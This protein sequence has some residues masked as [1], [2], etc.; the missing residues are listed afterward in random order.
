MLIWLQCPRLLRDWVLLHY[1]RYKHWALKA[2]LCLSWK[3]QT[4]GIM[5]LHLQA[6]RGC[7]KLYKLGGDPR[8]FRRFLLDAYFSR[9]VDHWPIFLTLNH[10]V[11]SASRRL[12]AAA[13]RPFGH[14]PI[15]SSNDQIFGRC[16]GGDRPDSRRSPL[17]VLSITAGRQWIPRS[18]AGDR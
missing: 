8:I 3:R 12:T 6:L 17:G 11:K 7:H 16:P 18:P 10:V 1:N 13:G 15:L 2:S 5:H 14:R 9:S 4:A